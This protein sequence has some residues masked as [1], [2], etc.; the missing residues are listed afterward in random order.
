MQGILQTDPDSLS[1]PP[2]EQH[3]NA[4]YNGKIKTFGPATYFNFAQKIS[5]KHTV[6]QHGPNMDETRYCIGQS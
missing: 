2:R 4:L 3:K 1:F 6:A 5:C